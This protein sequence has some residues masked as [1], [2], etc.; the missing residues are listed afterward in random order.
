MEKGKEWGEGEEKTM[1][2]RKENGVRGGGGEGKRKKKKERGKE[3]PCWCLN[4]QPL[5]LNLHFW[6]GFFFCLTPTVK[7]VAKWDLLKC[8]HSPQEFPKKKIKLIQSTC[9]RVLVQTD[10]HNL[11]FHLNK[12]VDF[13]TVR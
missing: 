12:T 1:G 8:S 9:S 6:K 5:V 4:S 11:T 13:K 7:V 2:D 3:K 10:T